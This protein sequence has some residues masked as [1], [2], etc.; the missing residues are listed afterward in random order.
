MSDA[1]ARFTEEELLLELIRRRG[2]DEAP[3]SRTM[4]DYEVLLGI[5]KGNYCYITFIKEDLE[6]LLAMK[7]EK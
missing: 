7:V 5:G 2:V 4:H 3:A 6:A 1:L